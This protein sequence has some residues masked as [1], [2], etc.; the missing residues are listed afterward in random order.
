M[1][2]CVQQHLNQQATL[3]RLDSGFVL[4]NFRKAKRIF[5]G[6]IYHPIPGFIA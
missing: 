3:I 1:Y 5:T 2:I 6:H 4:V